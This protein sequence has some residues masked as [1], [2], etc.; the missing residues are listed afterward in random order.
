VRL[1][2]GHGQFVRRF[3]FPAP[4]AVDEVQADFKDGILTVTL[5]KAAS[6]RGRRVEVS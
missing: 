2:R 4:L 1:E 3:T 5:P 6:A